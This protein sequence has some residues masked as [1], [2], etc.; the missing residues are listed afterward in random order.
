MVL[1]CIK[2]GKEYSENEVRYTCNCGGLLEVKLD[3]ERIKNEIDISQYKKHPPTVWKYSQFLPVKRRVSLQEGGTPLYF[4]D[5]LAEHIGLK[6]LFIK[7]EGMNPTG[8]FK[9]RGMTVGVSKAIE[10]DINKVACASTGNTSASM[11]AYA[12]KAQ[13]DAFVIIPSG[14]IALGKLAQAI[15][16]GAKVI[17]IKGNFDQSLELVSELCKRKE[18]YLLNSVNPFRLEGQ[19]TIAFEIWDQLGDVP[20]QVILPVGNA[21]NIS[22]IWKGFKEFYDAGIIDKLPKMIGVQA[23]GANPI[24]RYFKSK[25]INFEPVEKPETSATAIRIG[26]PVNWPKAVRAIKESSGTIIDVTDN[27]IRDAQT[28]IAN[29]EGIF[30]EPASAAPI[31]GLIKLIN[32]DFIKYDETIVA[33]ATGHGLKDP[34]FVLDSISVP[35]AVPPNINE[36]LKTIGL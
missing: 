36:L 30:V 33:I 20:D 22:A 10:L 26:N 25:E 34:N 27:E 11:A 18:I 31:A 23:L 15:I 4:T 12:A 5:N 24:V 35:K 9:D 3:I 2:C 19:K 28:L 13:L 1:R 7:H 16:Y 32:D 8:S 17:P 6:N 29:K 14:K 21:G